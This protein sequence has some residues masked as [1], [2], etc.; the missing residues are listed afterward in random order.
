MVK[1]YQVYIVC[2]A[3]PPSH[4]SLEFGQFFSQLIDSF[5]L[6]FLLCGHLL[7]LLH[8]TVLLLA[9]QLLQRKDQSKSQIR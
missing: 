8:V 7:L 1:A 4:F 9:Y 5:L 6:G 3:F 2:T